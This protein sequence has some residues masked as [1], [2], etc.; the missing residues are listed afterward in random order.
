MPFVV[1]LDLLPLQ[2]PARPFSDIMS[3][4]NSLCSKKRRKKQLGSKACTTLR[5]NSDNS[6]GCELRKTVLVSGA[7]ISAPDEFRIEIMT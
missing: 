3:E 7:S 4:D 5:T 6:W 2:S 1:T